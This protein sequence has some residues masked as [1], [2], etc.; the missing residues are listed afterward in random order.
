MFENQLEVLERGVVNIN[1]ENSLLEKLKLGRPLIVKAGFDPTAANLHLGHSVLLQK[2]KLFQDLGHK[3]VFVVGDFTAKIGDPTGKNKTRPPLSETQ[4]RENA[5]T[6]ADQVFKLLDKDKTQVVYNSAW[7]HKLSAEDMIKLASQQTVARMLEREDFN[8]RYKSGQAIAIHE[9]LYPI[10]QGY[11]SV[12]LK[13]D[14]EL[15]GTDQTF[16]LLVGRDMQKSAQQAPQII[17]T[18]PLLEGL[19]GVNKMSKSLGNTVDLTDKPSDMYGKI[20]SISDELMWR[21]W[22]LLTDVKNSELKAWQ[23]SDTNP[24]FIKEKL[25]HLLVTKWHNADWAEKAAADFA[26]RFSEGLIPSELEEVTIKATNGILPL[27]NILK[28]A[29]LVS[30]TSEAHRLIKQ[31]AVKIDGAK[32]ENNLELAA[33]S[34]MIIQVGKRRIKKVLIESESGAENA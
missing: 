17:M 19:D 20:M 22:E 11:D 26:S 3:V 18:L 28:A 4:I 1:P 21:Y 2:L 29:Q 7:M 31:S 13:A 9:F 32:I 27:A 33:G 24:K 16:N 15:G 14:I 5:K 25:A 6:Y 8:N 30:S 12:E 34:A 23:A 10:M